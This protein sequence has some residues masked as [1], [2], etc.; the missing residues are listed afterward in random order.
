MWRLGTIIGRKIVKRK[1]IREVGK[2]K[3][4]DKI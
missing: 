4:I 2:G 3:K 1:K